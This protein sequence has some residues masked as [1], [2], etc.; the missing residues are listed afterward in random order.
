M[1]HSID[2]FLYPAQSPLVTISIIDETES[3]ENLL[4][5][6]NVSDVISGENKTVL[7]PISDAWTRAQGTSIPYGTLVNTL[8]YLVIDG[9]YTTDQIINM[10]NSNKTTILRSNYKKTKLEFSLNAEKK[11][12]I[13]DRAMIVRSD[14]LTTTGII[15]LIDDVFLPTEV[16]TMD[17]GNS[18]SNSNNSTARTPVYPFYSSD[19]NRKSSFSSS[20]ITATNI[21]YLYHCIFVLILLYPE[22]IFYFVL[23]KIQ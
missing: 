6:L 9:L 10:M 2:S 4:K 12:V 3:M 22:N 18:N 17:D 23:Q 19:S 5:S 20:S 21:N 14:V 15:H 8:K 7:A 11:L 13:N 1:I 16:S